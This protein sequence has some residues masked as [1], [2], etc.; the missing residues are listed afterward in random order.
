MLVHLKA[1]PSQAAYH[2][3]LPVE[4]FD[5]NLALKKIIYVAFIAFD[6]ANR[7]A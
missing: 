5:D 2:P 1:F 6:V 3:K 4:Y 7:S